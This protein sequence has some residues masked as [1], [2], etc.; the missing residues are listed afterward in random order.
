MAA[1][2]FMKECVTDSNAPRKPQSYARS[3]R[4]VV[5]P[6]R[7][8]RLRSARE[9]AGFATMADAA[10]AFGWDEFTYRSH[11][12]GRRKYDETWAQRYGRAYRVRWTWLLSGQGLAQ[13]GTL[14][15]LSYVGAKAEVYPAETVLDQI[16]APPDCPEN[17]F[18]LVVR[19]DSMW[20]IFEDGDTLV[21]VPAP[22]EDLLGRRAI[23][24]L[25]DGRRL[26]KQIQPGDGPTHNLLSHN[27]APIMAARVVQA[28]KIIWH[29]PR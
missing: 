14:P 17:A 19:G 6:Q 9:Q 22:I 12:S 15:V 26:V 10:R 16:E 3:R 1:K 2:Q 27:D 28:A 8:E 11:E 18:A 5:M 7:H 21:C 24:D 29:K 23:V 20:P 4:S 25:D 13:K